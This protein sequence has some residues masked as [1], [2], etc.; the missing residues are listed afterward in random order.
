MQSDQC[1]SCNRYQML[2]TCEAFPDGIPQEI[3]EG[4]HDHTQPFE[5]DQ[6]LL[7]TPL[8]VEKE[9]K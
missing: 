8:V 9:P 2:K 4:S 3:Y 7:F 1:I 5:G 6:G